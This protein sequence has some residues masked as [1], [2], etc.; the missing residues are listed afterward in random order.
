[1]A[2][3]RVRKNGLVMSLK[4]KALAYGLTSEQVDTF[5]RLYRGARTPEAQDEITRALDLQSNGWRSANDSFSR[6]LQAASGIGVFGDD[7]DEDSDPPAL[8]AALERSRVV[9]RRR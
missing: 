1:M 6:V 2:L 3:T 7:D 9:A 8:T 5:E 4:A